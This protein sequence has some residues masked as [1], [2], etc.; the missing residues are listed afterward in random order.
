MGRL[1]HTGSAW[2][3]L[4]QIQRLVMHYMLTVFI[5]KTKLSSSYCLLIETI[6]TRDGRRLRI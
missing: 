1:L 2:I 4:P 3:G 5:K 6:I